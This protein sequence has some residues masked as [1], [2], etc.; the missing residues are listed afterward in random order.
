[1]TQD[2]P[3]LFAGMAA[4]LAGWGMNVVTADAF[5]NASGV[6]VDSF[7]FTDTFRTLELNERERD[8]FI[9]SVRDLIAGRSSVETLL[10]GRRRGRR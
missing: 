2:R 6:I 1:V 10:S 7:R 8:R 5:A 4:A 3:R 9:S